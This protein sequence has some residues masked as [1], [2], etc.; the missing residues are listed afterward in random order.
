MS[1]SRAVA[2][3]NSEKMRLRTA[4][5]Y[6]NNF[7]KELR[8]QRNVTQVKLSEFATVPI[9]PS[10]TRTLKEYSVERKYRSQPVKHDTDSSEQS[11]IRGRYQ[12]ATRPN[13]DWETLANFRL[14]HADMCMAPRDEID[15]QD[16][17]PSHTNVEDHG[18]VTSG[19]YSADDRYFLTPLRDVLPTSTMMSRGNLLMDCAR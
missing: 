11:P 8:R 17:L 6:S 2:D 16:T 18:F 7:V 9:P 3:D 12:R 10:P 13:A 1:R 5:L 19:C 15:M 4:R 14:S